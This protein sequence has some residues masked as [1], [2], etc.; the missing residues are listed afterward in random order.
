MRT[1]VLFV[2]AVVLVA[3]AVH[4]QDYVEVVYLKDGRVFRGLVVAEEVYPQPK[5]TIETPDGE[6]HTFPKSEIDRVTRERVPVDRG[7]PAGGLQPVTPFDDGPAPLSDFTW[8][9]NLLGLLQFG[10]YARLHFKVAEELTVSPHLRIGYLGL[11][12]LILDWWA[13]IGVGVSVLSYLPTEI[14]SNRL[15]Y[16]GILELQVLGEDGSFL[17]GVGLMGNFGHRWYNR[18]GRRYLQVGLLAGVAYDLV[19]EAVTAVAMA[20]LGLGWVPKER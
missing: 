19:E 2:V 5:L 10:P 15:Y 12:Y 13:E 11:L 18:D 14:G 1:A 20:E 7:T 16:G 3:A 8:E 17:P 6:R 4:A 9:V